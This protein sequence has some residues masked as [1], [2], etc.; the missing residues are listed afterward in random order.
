MV[1]PTVEPKTYMAYEQHARLHIT[2]PLGGI[3]LC[4]LRRVDC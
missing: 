4:N 3:Q 1:K 2:P